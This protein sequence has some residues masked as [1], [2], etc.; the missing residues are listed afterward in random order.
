MLDGIEDKRFTSN[1]SITF[2][3]DG[4]FST[5]P[6]GSQLYKLFMRKPDDIQPYIIQPVFPTKVAA[7]QAVNEFAQSFTEGVTGPVPLDEKLSW[8]AKEAAAKAVIAGEATLEQQ[9]LLDDE[10]ALT[11]ET[12]V[13]LANTIVSKATIYRQVVSRVAGLRRVLTAQIEA[14]TDPYNYDL[15][16]EAGKTQAE[17]LA[18]SIGLSS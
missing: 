17:Q 10:A 1:G 8:D 7:L 6:K 16:L 3:K 18:N 9:S 5:A 4:S 15:I 12:T 2:F 14:E 13:N 11:S